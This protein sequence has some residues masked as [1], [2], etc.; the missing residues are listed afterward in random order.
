MNKRL[1]A[2]RGRLLAKLNQM[3]EG[4][5]ISLN[6]LPALGAGEPAR[7]WLRPCDLHRRWGISDNGL[8]R[9]ERL[10]KIPPRDVIEDRKP[11]G[12]FLT[13]IEKFETEE[14]FTPSAAL[15]F[16]KRKNAS[17]FRGP[18]SADFDFPNNHEKEKS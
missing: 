12:W 1:A 9:W 15:Q 10:L 5:G 4:S 11:V 14:T 8:W 2:V 16:L 3:F 7:K 6:H 13:T 17:R 18:G